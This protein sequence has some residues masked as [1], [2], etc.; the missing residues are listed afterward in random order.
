MQ[1]LVFGD[2]SPSSESSDSQGC[3]VEDRLPAYGENIPD[4]EG[5][6]VVAVEDVVEEQEEWQ[7]AREEQEVGGESREGGG[8]EAN[9]G[10][11]DFNVEYM[12]CDLCHMDHVSQS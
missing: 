5:E 6:V 10:G 9:N 3:E 4:E 11:D 7:D 12:F 8:L 2:A 1:A